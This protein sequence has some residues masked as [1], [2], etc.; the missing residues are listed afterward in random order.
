LTEQDTTWIVEYYRNGGGYSSNE[1]ETYFQQAEQAWAA[2]QTS[3]SATS[4]QQLGQSQSYTRPAAMRDYL[5]TR[6]SQKEPFDILYFTP[7]VTAIANLHDGSFSLAPELLYTGITNLEL[8]LK[9]TAL[10][11][12]GRSEYGEKVNDARVELRMRWYF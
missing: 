7:A 8:R 3:A 12:S 11:G 6:V 4:L 2:W 1:M 9:G 10:V 5:Y